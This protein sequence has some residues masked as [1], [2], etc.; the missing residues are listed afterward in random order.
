VSHVRIWKFRPPADREGEFAVAYSADGAWAR[1]F[2]SAAGF[3]GT[4]L[5]RPMEPGGWWMT[6]DRWQSES[7]FSAFQAE[8]GAEYR[9]LD[10]ELEGCAGEE[11]FVGAFED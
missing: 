8:Q 6:V 11:V 10:E 7:A 1:L 2:G 5:L 4:E 3:L 9:R